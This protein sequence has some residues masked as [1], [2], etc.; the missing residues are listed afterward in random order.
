[1]KFFSFFA[2]I[3]GL[4]GLHSIGHAQPGQSSTGAGAAPSGVGAAPQDQPS[5][6]GPRTVHSLRHANATTLAELLNT[7][8]QNE[9]KI[10]VLPAGNAL[11]I[12]ASPAA[13]EEIAK[14]LVQ[15]DQ[16]SKMVEVE[17]ILAEVTPKKAADGKEP[18]DPNIPGATGDVLAKL[19]SLRKDGQIASYQ[20]IKLTALEGQAV[21]IQAG[22]NKPYTSAS[23]LTATGAVQR[24]VSYHPEVTKVKATARVG[25]ENAV[26]VDLHVADSR[27]KTAE[28]RDEP[29]AVPAPPP[30]PA[31]KQPEGGEEPK[32]GRGRQPGAGGFPGAA[33][34]REAADSTPGASFESGSLSTKVVVSSGKPVIVQA[35]RTEG[36]AG[37]TTTLVIVTARVVDAKSK[38]G[39]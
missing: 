14:L 3:I 23:M 22:G 20:R 12:T 37:N 6:K 8:F 5:W 35:V 7:H 32:L 13:T 2:A 31:A 11:L 19:E 38:S 33:R 1:M 18:A 25:P 28:P 10:S 36:K 34:V 29:K 16:P 24:S 30:A 39:R 9:A 15:L 17:V 27:I 26:A 4:L 21:E